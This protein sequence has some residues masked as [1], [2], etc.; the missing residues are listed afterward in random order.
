MTKTILIAL[1]LL[2]SVVGA[3]CSDDGGSTPDTNKTLDAALDV[4]PAEAGADTNPA[5]CMKGSDPEVV[6]F[7]TDDN[8]KLEADLYLSGQANA[9]AVVLLHMVPPANSRAN[10]PLAFVQ[11]LRAKGFN[12]LNVDRRGAGN[13]AGNAMDAYL[14]DKGKLDAKAAVAFLAA[15]ACAMNLDKLALVGAS[16]GTTT[17][18]DYTVAADGDA[19]Q[20]SPAALVF[21]SGGTYT[22]AQNT[23]AANLSK[24]QLP[25]LFAYPASE[26]SWND[27][28]KTGA[29]A[30]WQFKQYAGT[31]HGTGLF[32]DKPDSIADVADFLA[33]AL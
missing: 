10:F 15:H 18:L 19:Q 13:S 16:N 22:E 23:L 32:S 33:G 5:A 17:V 1:G 21:L 3:G 9:A 31:A 11:A 24:L 25:L 26:A 27:G 8:V 29:P 28:F 4:G 7:T 20:P 14:G 2:L 6:T 30:G 12:V